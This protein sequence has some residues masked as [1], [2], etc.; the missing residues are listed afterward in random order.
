M[1]NITGPA[2]NQTRLE[3]LSIGDTFIDCEGQLCMKI[4]TP[5]YNNVVVLENGYT[6]WTD[7]DIEVTPVECTL[8]YDYV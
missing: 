7:E 4:K 6:Y 1:I 5:D 8:T 3:R 2:P